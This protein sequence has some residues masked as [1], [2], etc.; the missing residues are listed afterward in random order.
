MSWPVALRML[1]II[2]RRQVH[3]LRTKTAT[4]RVAPDGTKKPKKTLGFLIILEKRI[5]LIPFKEF[6]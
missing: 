1:E 6:F 3:S 4:K 5:F 2:P